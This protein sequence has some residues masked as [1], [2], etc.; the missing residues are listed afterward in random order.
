MAAITICND[1]GAQENKVSHCFPF[2]CH[3]VMGRDAMICF[4]NDELLANFFTLLFHFHQEAFEFLFPF[5]HK[6]G[7]ICISEVIDISPGNLDSSL[8]FF[9]SSFAYRLNKQGGNIQ[10]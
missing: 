1:F 4:L 5:C 9:Q 3:E 7:V 10:P 2:I 8:C 6:G